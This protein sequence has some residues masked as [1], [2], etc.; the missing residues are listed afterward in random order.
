MGLDI[1]EAKL[2]NDNDKRRNTYFEKQSRTNSSIAFSLSG[3]DWGA[4]VSAS[5][6]TQK[7]SKIQKDNNGERQTRRSLR[8]RRSV[9]EKING[10]KE[11]E[12][13]RGRNRRRGNSEPRSSRQSKGNRRPTN[14]KSHSPSGI[15]NRRGI[16]AASSTTLEVSGGKMQRNSSKKQVTRRSISKEKAGMPTLSKIKW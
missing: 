2:L 13:R 3:V 15:R 11:T 14:S 7:L 4:G 12:D 10:K 9:D 1:A 6:H 5:V 8:E 16:A